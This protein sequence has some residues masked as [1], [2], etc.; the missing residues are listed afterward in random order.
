[1]NLWMRNLTVFVFALVTVTAQTP[2]RSGTITGRV[3]N[4]SGQPL[5]NASITIYSVG[6][7]QQQ[8]HNGTVTDRD[9]KFQLGGLEPRS[10]RLVAWLNS[11]APA[12]SSTIY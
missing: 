8:Q 9:G 6:S 4:E 11:Y 7:M 12:I 3:V 1:M 10:Y 2:A 5:A